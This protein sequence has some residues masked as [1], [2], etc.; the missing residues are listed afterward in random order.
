VHRASATSA[1]G[2]GRLGVDVFCQG[3]IATGGGAD[4][5]AN[6]AADH[7]KVDVVES[8][9]LASSEGAHPT[10]WQAEG[11][12]DVGLVGTYTITAFVVC[13]PN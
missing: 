5:V 2:G 12:N 13:A 7:D 10:G 9:P 1:V 11:D 6:T 3:G 8:Q 4:I